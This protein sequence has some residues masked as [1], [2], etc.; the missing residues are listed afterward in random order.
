MPPGEP[1]RRPAFA[2]HALRFVVL[3]GLVSLFADATYEG[4]RSVTGPFLGVLGASA[5]AVGVVAGAGELLGY[6]LRL[7]SGYLSDRTGRYWAVT[8]TGYT[9][10]LFAVPAL[11]LAGNW[12]AAAL[13]V[14]AE[15]AGKA[16]RTPARDAMLSYATAGAGAGRAF[17]LHE[18]LDQV[19]AIAGPLA[20]ASLLLWRHSYR[21][22]FAVL[23]LPALAALATLALARRAYPE[24]AKLHAPRQDDR[25]PGHD[26]P[27]T[28]PHGQAGSRLPRAFWLYLVPVGLVAAGYADF[29]LIAYHF[30]RKAVLSSQGIPLLY[31]L[32]MGADAV[33]ALLF[34][35]LFDR[36][37]PRALAVAAA[38][39]FPFAP[40]VFLGG[41]ALAAAG[42]A[43]W[44]VGMGAQESILRAAVA[45]LVPPDRRGTGFGA[46]NA[47]YGLAW[48]AGSALLGL[49][50]EASIAAVV[51]FSVGLQLLAIPLFLRAG[52]AGRAAP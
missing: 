28:R 6:G 19:G 25:L 42:A 45:T 32:A 39:S 5:A 30:E 41:P 47:A 51:A 8:F 38:V 43:L 40:L 18:A 14:L 4:A 29:A 7:V 11:A 31:A 36:I 10:N 20:V 49:L 3:L 15:R 16:I 44:G 22:A 37:G 13:L 35:R 34:G 12:P 33:A 21:L 24:P 46:F 26:R 1:G 17:G 50:Y 48:F 23:V 27:G 2:G 52:W 9:L